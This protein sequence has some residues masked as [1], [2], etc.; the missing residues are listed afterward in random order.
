MSILSN[1]LEKMD[2]IKEEIKED[3]DSILDVIDLNQLLSLDKDGIDIYIKEI[4][5][6]YWEVQEPLIKKSIELGT[7]KGK[8]LIRAI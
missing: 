5:L 2:D 1:H 4:L 7:K 8:D 6:D 3:A